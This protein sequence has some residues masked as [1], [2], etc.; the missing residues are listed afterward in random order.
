MQYDPDWNGSQG[1][2]RAASFT[3][4]GLPWGQTSLFRALASRFFRALKDVVFRTRSLSHCLATITVKMVLPTPLWNLLCSCWCTLLLIFPPCT[5]AKCLAL[6]SSESPGLLKGCFNFLLSNVFSRLNKASFLSLLA[7]FITE[8]VLL[9]LTI[10]VIWLLV[11][12]PTWA[13]DVCCSCGLVSTVLKGEITSLTY[14]LFGSTGICWHFLELFWYSLSS[15]G[16]E[17]WIVTQIVK[18]SGIIC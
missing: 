17:M 18:V 7:L 15:S 6:S 9:P 11:R 3:K 16:Q 13:L 10:F 14:W 1:V 12:R 2:S 4:G 5:P 8:Q